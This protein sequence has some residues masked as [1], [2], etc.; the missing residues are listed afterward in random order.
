[1]LRFWL[2]AILALLL[3]SA[4]TAQTA[5]V[6]TGDI[7]QVQSGQLRVFD[8]ALSVYQN[9]GGGNAGYNA[10]GYSEADNFLYG[11]QGQNLIRID[12]NGVITTLFALGFTSSSA[13]MDD[14]NNL[15]IQRSGI[16]IT[17]FNVVSGTA[18]DLTLTGAALPGG[19]VD[20]AFVKTAVGDRLVGVGSANVS[21]V[22]PITGAT[23]LNAVASYPNEGSSGATWGD[24]NGRV[25]TFKNTTGNVYEI[26][27][28]LTATPYAVLVARGVPSTSNDGASCRSKPFPTLAP[29]A[30]DDAFT[31]S[32]QTVLTA[33]VLADN[34]SGADNDPDGTPLTVSPTPV[35][36]VTNGTLTLSTDGSFT[37]TPAPGFSGIDQFVYRV[38]DTTGRTATATVR[39]TI[40]RAV[41]TLKKTGT[42]YKP[43]A[44]YPFFLPLNDL[45]YGVE[46]T[47]TG[48]ETNATGSLLIVDPL[49]A[50]TIFLNDDIDQGGP[51]TFAGTDPVGW[52]NSASGLTFSYLQDVAY[53]D[54]ATAPASFAQ[55]TYVPSAGYDAAVRHVCINPKG[56]LL[57]GGKASFYFRS[58]IK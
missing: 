35:T 14:A 45:I 49:P 34:G 17:R 18:T 8:P 42:L 44:T 56:A 4:A 33:N 28:Y 7:Y 54:Q 50:D 43:T 31:T 55:C 21:V 11:I 41:I 52:V 36:I 12:A 13:D 26:K 1:M 22:D 16:L 47:N 6:C 46:V 10:I 2:A 20:I 15:W 27:D 5:F 25:F 40:T 51:D 39:I 19:G 53:S 29:L 57:P 30:F 24:A 38:A 9:I 48:N 32:Y 3:P 23:V 37:Y 58:K